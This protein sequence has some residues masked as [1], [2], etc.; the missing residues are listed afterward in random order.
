MEGKG[1]EGGEEGGEDAIVAIA[2]E[3]VLSVGLGGWG[4]ER[5]SSCSAGSWRAGVVLLLASWS[6]SVSLSHN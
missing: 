1:E 4:D 3:E 5:R 6:T 2:V